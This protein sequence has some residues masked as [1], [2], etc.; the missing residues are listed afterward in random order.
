MKENNH[1]VVCESIQSKSLSS[2]VQ[3]KHIAYSRESNPNALQGFI[4]AQIEGE[5]FRSEDKEL[6]A[7][8]VRII[9]EVITLP[10]GSTVRIEGN[11]LRAELVAYQ[12]GYLTHEHIKQVLEN[13]KRITHKI[14]HI[15]TYLRTALYNSVSEFDLQTYNRIRSD[16]LW[17]ANQ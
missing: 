8:I 15:K 17:F 11:D 13:Y 4:N 3:Q 6:V 9:T 2:P 14:T 10:E 1:S 7:S 12:Y 16:M 5:C